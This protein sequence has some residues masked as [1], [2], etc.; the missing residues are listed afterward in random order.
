MNESNVHVKILELLNKNGIIQWSLI[1]P[2]E[3][4]LVLTN[5]SQFRLY[6]DPDSDKWNDLVMNGEKVTKYDDK[7]FFKNSGKIFA[8]RG[9]VLKLNTDDKFNTTNSP[10]GKPIIEFMDE[11]RFD[12]HARGKNLRDKNL[13]KS[14]FQKSASLASWL[15]RSERPVF[16]PEKSNEIYDRLCLIMEE[17]QAE[18]DTT[19]FDDDIVAII[20]ELLEYKCINPIQHK[21][22]IKKLNLL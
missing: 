14:N 6:H 5:G 18:K 17:K 20:D 2:K 3:K 22:N 12:V 1:T 15:K 7:I 16:I 11:I 13:I 21:K 4:L 9:D 10:D 8:L 19:R